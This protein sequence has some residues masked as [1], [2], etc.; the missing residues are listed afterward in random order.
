MVRLARELRGL[1]QTQL[2]EL[3]GIPQA[4]LSRIEGG[5]KEA[6]CVEL[7]QLSATIGLPLAFFEEPDVPAAAPLFRKRAIRS[8]SVERVIQARVNTAVLVARRRMEA[9]VEV[10]TPLAFP[11]PGE[12][13]RGDPAAAAA[14]LR[15]SWRM[16]NGRVD[17]VTALI[18]NAGGVV[19]HVD[20]GVDNA[21][22]AFLCTIGD[23]RL[24]FLVN[25]RETAGDRV[26]LS[27]AHE[28]GHAM[29]HRYVPVYDEKRLEPEAYNFAAA[30][31]LPPG[32]MSSL[33]DPGLTLS[34]ARDLKRA[35]WVSIQAIIKAAADRRLISAARYMSLYK[36]IS[37]RGWRHVEPDPVPVERPRLW[38]AVVELHREK[39]GYSFEEL[40]AIARV[41]IDVM[42]D[43]FP[44]EFAGRLR[45]IE[46]GGSEHGP[47]P[48]PLQP[49]RAV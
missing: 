44:R 30:L 46:G 41:S 10:Q 11:E 36:Q 20:F 38:P 13:P 24:W 16:P 1:T 21:S 9:G 12:F 6:T 14:A 4:S 25:T 5:L 47:R 26:R 48:A 8:V 37:A 35:Y 31:M 22:A 32:E 2:G 29:L 39:H 7:E 40:A 49:L 3:S 33:V 23:P 28:L 27:L 15:R 17:S 42:A 18:E 19:L 34:R 43:L 45:A